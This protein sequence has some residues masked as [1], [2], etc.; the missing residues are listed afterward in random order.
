M[1]IFLDRIVRAA[2]LD[3]RVYEEVEADQG[4]FWQAFGVVALSG[5]ATVVGITGRFNLADLLSGC[6]LG[7]L[8][9]AAWAA[10]AYLVGTRVFPEPQTRADWGELLRTTGF[11][12][13]PGILSILGVI[14]VFTG[15]ITLAV[16]VW[17]LMSFAV[18][19]R[20]ALDYRSTLRAVGVCLVGWLL[21]AGM[22]LGMM[23]H[24]SAS[25][26]VGAPGLSGRPAIVKLE[27]DSGKP[28]DMITAYGTSLDSS[29]V[30]YVY[31]TDGTIIALVHIFEQ[32]ATSIRFKIPAM[33]ESGC[34]TVVI[35]PTGGYARAIPQPVSLTVK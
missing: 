27:P 33:L 31:L 35:R 19:V 25:V 9:W 18:A 4:A 26:L 7:I 8:A 14:P 23:S 15:F 30:E 20:Q 32:G 29:T 17:M 10:I 6:V 12:T 21:Y 24:A 2:R 11:A 1:T 3:S 13:A 28:G 22:L 16:T 34:Y 5:M